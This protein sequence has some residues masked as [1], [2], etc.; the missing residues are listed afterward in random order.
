MHAQEG[1]E[2]IL[3]VDLSTSDLSDQFLT[4]L[5][6]GEIRFYSVAGDVPWHKNGRSCLLPPE[7]LG[8]YW[9]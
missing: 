4:I 1:N 2:V 3:S 5:C 8:V 6:T 7:F 9:L